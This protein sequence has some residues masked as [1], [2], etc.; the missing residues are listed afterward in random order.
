[1]ERERKARSSLRNMCPGFWFSS[2]HPPLQ[3]HP[4]HRCSRSGRIFPHKGCAGTSILPRKTAVT[5]V[6]QKN[7]ALR[8]AGNKTP[9]RYFRNNPSFSEPFGHEIASFRKVLNQAV[10]G[11]LSCRMCR[12]RVQSQTRSFSLSTVDQ[13][14]AIEGGLPNVALFLATVAHLFSEKASHVGGKRTC[15]ASSLAGRN[16]TPKKASPVFSHWQSEFREMALLEEVPTGR[17]GPDLEALMRVSS[18]VRFFC[19]GRVSDVSMDILSELK[20]GG[21]DLSS[22]RSCWWLLRVHSFWENG[23]TAS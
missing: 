10:W 2:P 18:F 1:M 9:G 13:Y 15:L 21:P 14:D 22:F 16:K 8:S 11:P 20:L 6:L 12:T 23:C 4:D 17:R 5:A 19:N 7:C 3:R